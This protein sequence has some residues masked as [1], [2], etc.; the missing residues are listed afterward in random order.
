MPRLMLDAR[1]IY[2]VLDMAKRLDQW[3]EETD[4][5][6]HES[7]PLCGTAAAEYQHV[8]STWLQLLAVMDGEREATLP[9]EFSSKC[10]ELIFR[11]AM[12]KLSAPVPFENESATFAG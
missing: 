8:F 9:L 4:D 11:C 7:D 1:R 5:Q 6:H 3:C 2:T 10:Y 12:S